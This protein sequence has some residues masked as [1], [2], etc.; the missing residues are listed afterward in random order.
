MW[1]SCTCSTHSS[2]QLRLII[3]MTV[4]IVA[5]SG[6]A[7]TVAFV[8]TPENTATPVLFVGT[9]HEAAA[10]GPA[11]SSQ[12]ATSRHASRGAGAGPMHGANGFS[13]DTSRL[14]YP[15]SK[16]GQASIVS[17]LPILM[18]SSMLGNHHNG[19]GSACRSLEWR[20]D[21][22]A[23]SL[24]RLPMYTSVMKRLR[25]MPEALQSLL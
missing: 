8:G 12:N 7:V 6:I 14:M 24:S 22:Y 16:I 9:N 5:A 25:R 1:S 3:W 20:T 10:L 15:M 11:G 17:N 19:L 13:Q 21:L 2:Q 4:A 18:R 23:G